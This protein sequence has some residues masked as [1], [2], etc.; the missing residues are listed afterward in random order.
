MS[1]AADFWRATPGVITGRFALIFAFAV[2]A[3]QEAYGVARDGVLGMCV[4]AA[5]LVVLLQPRRLIFLLALAAMVVVDVCVRFETSFNHWLFAGLLALGVV[6]C[7]VYAVGRGA[8]AGVSA[9]LV[10]TRL[11]GLLL[12]SL[13]ALYAVAGFHKL[14][15]DFLQ[16]SESCGILLGAKALYAVGLPTHASLSPVFIAGTLAVELGMPLLLLSARSR[17][18]VA[19]I[20]AGF[21]A[22]CSL[23]GYPRFSAL[24]LACMAPLIPAREHWFDRT[25]RPEYWWARATLVAALLVLMLQPQKVSDTGILLVNLSFV[26][27]FGV[28]GAQSLL[29]GREQDARIAPAKRGLWLV[30]PALI[31]GLGMAP[32]LGLWTERA[33]GMYSN[34]RT[35]GGRSNHLIMRPWMQL[36]DYQRQLAVVVHDSG[37]LVLPR[38]SRQRALPML[39]VHHRLLDRL[40]SQPA[41]VGFT[42]QVTV[43]LEGQTV[44]LGAP[45]EGSS[46]YPLGRQRT[47]LRFR[48]IEETGPRACGV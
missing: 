9:I 14:N 11:S 46:R 31:V 28:M 20:G 15:T 10:E 42:E 2:L 38:D 34:V 22:L 48:A 47:L 1:W 43:L 27:A 12:S 7:C 45:T 23:A 17:P 37:Q 24:S 3:H 25:T 30:T 39:E 21:H 32:Y 4:T 29:P 40:S 16:S 35:E 5:A 6:V 19:V 41:S 44:R 18:L 33:F 13:G 8:S 36:F 26:C